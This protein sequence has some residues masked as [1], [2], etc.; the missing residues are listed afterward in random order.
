MAKDYIIHGVPPSLA[1][2]GWWL[3]DTKPKGTAKPS[4]PRF[5]EKYSAG[6][7]GL[8]CAVLLLVL[9][10]DFLFW[11][12]GLGLNL[13]VFAV[14]VFIVATWNV[15]PYR[16]VLL[17]AALLLAGALP[18][19]EYVQFLSVAI[20]ALALLGALTWARCPKGGAD[21]LL[22]GT[23]HLMRHLILHVPKQLLGFAAVRHTLV[24]PQGGAWLRNWAFPIGGTLIFAAILFDANPLFAR[25]LEFEVDLFALLNRIMFWVGV[26]LLVW[27]LLQGTSDTGPLDMPHIGLRISKM[28]IN[29]GSTLRALCM[30]NALIGL[31]TVMDL[32]LFLGG[33]SLPEG[34]TYASYAHRGAYPLLATALLAGGFALLARPFLDSHRMIKPLMLI[35]LGQNIALSLSAVLR[36]DL[37][38]DVYGLTYLRIYALIWMGLVAA[39]LVLIAWQ[40]WSAQPNRWLLTNMALLGGITLYFCAFV[41]FAGIIAEKN[42]SLQRTDLN[43]VCGLGPAAATKI[44]EARQRDP[45][46]L[47]G[48]FV[49][50]F[51]N[52]DWREWGF[53]KWRISH[54]FVSVSEARL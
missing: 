51:Q 4:W 43:Y 24:V 37:Y 26:A 33:A 44:A 54:S 35:W 42:L 48:C 45:D 29:A 12:R 47:N 3:S 53:R 49:A 27:P 46:A 40:V 41:N 34:M 19:I 11:G 14:G 1:F 39:G 9:L 8:F 18:V 32:S 17:P 13:A 31:Q 30:F 20:L 6:R 36:L 22:Q 2:D 10:A 7:S 50:P 5:S 21:I 38:I 52:Q 25:L 15:R 16:K 28:G 23:V